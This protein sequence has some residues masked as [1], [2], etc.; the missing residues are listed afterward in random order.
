MKK[1][2]WLN[3][4][5]TL[6]MLIF[7]AYKNFHHAQ[8]SNHLFF[9]VSSAAQDFFIQLRCENEQKET[10]K[11]GLEQRMNPVCSVCFIINEKPLKSLYA[12]IRKATKQSR[13]WSRAAIAF[14][15]FSD[16]LNDRSEY[17]WADGGWI[18]VNLSL[19]MFLS[20]ALVLVFINFSMSAVEFVFNVER[21]IKV[22]VGTALEVFFIFFFWQF[23]F[24]LDF[25]LLTVHY[26][27]RQTFEAWDHAVRF[28]VHDTSWRFHTFDE[29]DGGPRSLVSA[30]GLERVN[31]DRPARKQKFEIKFEASSWKKIFTCDGSKK[32]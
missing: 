10:S 20:P 16:L 9:L 21:E 14:S 4:L 27:R 18:N 15:E 2:T 12:E 31:G 6:L 23:Q 26:Q 25:W 24:V 13:Q 1:T 28:P 3:D 30:C 7:L 17:S 19:W 22:L 32:R 5:Q 11:T 29:T 8:L